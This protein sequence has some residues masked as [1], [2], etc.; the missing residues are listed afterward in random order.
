M[1]H[2]WTSLAPSD[3]VI[4]S[5]VIATRPI[6]KGTITW[7]LDPLDL[8]LDA[9]QTRWMGREM[10]DRYTFPDRDGTPILCWDLGRFVNHRCRPN[11]MSLALRVDLAVRDI[12]AGEEISTDYA[13]LNLETPFA[14]ACGDPACRGT[15]RP[16]DFERLAAGWDAALQEAVA[17]MPAVPQPLWSRLDSSTRHLLEETAAG[18]REAPSVLEHRYRGRGAD[19]HARHGR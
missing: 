7:F 16:E 12:G 10:L 8:R 4:G 14:C 3:P 6:P 15:V 2:P 9:E 18:R 11:T 1:I 19:V 5:G 17:Q 13:L